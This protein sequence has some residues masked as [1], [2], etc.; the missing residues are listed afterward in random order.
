MGAF[1]QWL[2]ALEERHLADLRLSELTRA[3]RA[4][5]RVYVERRR[6]ADD[7][8]RSR[9]HVRGALESAGKR[10]A[11]ALFFA[12][13][14]FLAA[15]GVVLALGAHAPPLSSILDLG[16]GSGAAGG[17]W[18]V[19]AGGPAVIGVDRHGWAVR[20]ARWTYRQLGLRG[21]T[22]QGT[23]ARLPPLRAGTGVIA[24]YVLNELP[25]AV[26][27]RVEDQL[28]A[29]AGRGAPILVL[30]PIAR[31]VTPW[32]ISMARRIQ[33]AGGRSDEWR[34]R[35]DLPPL[36]QRLDEAAGLDHRE[37]TVR[38]LYCPGGV[39]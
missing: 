7:L 14:H 1:Q 31:G 33:V 11:F 25:D 28:F 15:D 3:V 19:A 37:I 38:S 32:W 29:A 26:R 6:G 17:A 34:F 39:G 36:L 22:R 2:A 24:A 27:E 13:L 16:C 35:V 4:L 21:H 5:S 18:A 8:R 10:A 23:I 9:S 20:E 12:P 30:E